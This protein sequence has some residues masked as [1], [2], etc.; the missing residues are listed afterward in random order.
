MSKIIKLP[1]LQEVI[2][3]LVD[4]IK[5]RFNQ[6]VVAVDFDENTNIVTVSKGDGQT[7]T[8]FSLDKFVDEW[9]DL[10]CVTEYPYA[11]LFDYTER[12]DDKK[13]EPD[14]SVITD[15]GTSSVIIEI[16]GGN[17]YSIFRQHNDNHNIVFY[18]AAD[19]FISADTVQ[20]P[21]SGGWHKKVVNAPANATKMAVNFRKNGQSSHLIMVIKGD[22]INEVTTHI[23][24][25]DGGRILI[26]DCVTLSF[27]NNG[28]TLASTTHESAIKE[29]DSKVTT[30]A[31]GTVTS[32]NGERPD[33]QGNVQIEIINIPTLQ[34]VLD[35]KVNTADLTKLGGVQN[36]EKI[37][38]LDD[39]GKLHL[40]MLPDISI[41]RVHSVTNHQEAETLIQNG[42]AAVGDI[43]IVED[44][45]NA[46]YMYVNDQ[47]ADFTDKCVEL[48]M[49]NGTVKKVNGITADPTGNVTVTAN[50]IT[51]ANGQSTVEIELG[52]KLETINNQPATNG[53]IDLGVGTTNTD[54][55]LKV[56]NHVY[57]SVP[58]ITSQQVTEIIN[59]FI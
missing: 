23:P 32:V 17:E 25:L 48:T 59:L 44:E 27:D 45:G 31:G 42:T 54:I 10:D 7:T 1:H 16:L 13:Y 3:D 11:N 15:T 21:A 28:T 29:L 12:M 20:A 26:G 41:N 24:Y 50:D 22:V 43:F 46:V 14:G 49:A 52:K 47:G 33:N 40:S 56:G 51:L 8:E 34:D 2:L 55:E 35:G 30:L 6:T 58:Y 39:Q 37:P 18:D 57:G 5:L 4:K 19:Q 36:A 38:Q 53:N 9:G